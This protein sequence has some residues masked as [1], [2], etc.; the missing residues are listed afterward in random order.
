MAPFCLL[1]AA[2]SLL[3]AGLARSA[4]LSL[5]L[6]L[7]SV[8]ANNAF[9][10][11]M[12]L[13]NE[14]APRESIGLVNGA[15]QTL[16]SFVRALG[17]ALGGGL[18]GFAS[19]SLR[20]PLGQFLPFFLVSLGLVASSLVY[21]K[22]L[23]RRGSWPRRGRRRRRRRELPISWCRRRR[24][25]RRRR[26]GKGSGE[27]RAFSS[28]SSRPP[29]LSGEDDDE[30]RC[31]GRDGQGR[32]RRASSFHLEQLKNRRNEKTRGKKVLFLL[33]IQCL[34]MTYILSLVIPPF[35]VK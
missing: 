32:R 12:V 5:L 15:G 14:A 29:V 16:A 28:S 22:V 19:T 30:R 21:T 9:T 7:R 23:R 31:R 34:R 35:F 25:R 18:W 1:L 26:A 27:E 2:P 6:V 17:P 3:P 10:S 24:A 33:S 4:A 13:V 8:F 20:P 11:S